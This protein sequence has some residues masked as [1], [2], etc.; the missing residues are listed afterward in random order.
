MHEQGN[1]ERLFVFQK[2]FDQQSTPPASSQDFVLTQW[3]SPSKRTLALP[4]FMITISP[5]FAASGTWQEPFIQAQDGSNP[6]RKTEKN[7]DREDRSRFHDR[8]RKWN[9][10]TLNI[11]LW[12][13]QVLMLMLSL[14]TETDQP[15]SVTVL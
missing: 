7:D 12:P 4:Q 5:K 8:R 11:V 13:V 3:P 2:I 6:E 1:Q 14:L 15:Y 10:N 9:K